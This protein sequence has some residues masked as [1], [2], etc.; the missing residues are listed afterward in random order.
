MR[1]KTLLLSF[2]IFKK[3]LLS[4]FSYDIIARGLAPAEIINPA[5]GILIFTKKSSIV[6][7]FSKKKVAISYI[8]H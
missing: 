4:E 8:S 5:K 1:L 6:L 2:T 7:Q 3:W